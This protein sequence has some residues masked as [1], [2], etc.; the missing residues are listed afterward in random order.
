M[1]QLNNREHENAITQRPCQYQAREKSPERVQHNVG[2][3]EGSSPRTSYEA[4][5]EANSMPVFDVVTPPSTEELP[6]TPCGMPHSSVINES[7]SYD[8]WRSSMT[9]LLDMEAEVFQHMSNLTSDEKNAD[10]DLY[11]E[12]QALRKEN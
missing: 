10:H 5:A 1:V 2:E 7:A 6:M 3:R 4:I 8:V 12:N 9:A 11:E